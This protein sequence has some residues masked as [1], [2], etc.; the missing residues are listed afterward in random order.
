VT[1]ERH[2]AGYD[3]GDN[4]PS[5]DDLAHSVPHDELGVTRLPKRAST[6]TTRILATSTGGEHTLMLRL[7]ALVHAA[8]V[9]ALSPMGIDAAIRLPRGCHD[10]LEEQG[11]PG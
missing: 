3:A 2:R 4:Q 8:N 9:V 7:P 10:D 11:S 5:Q 1:G 6:V